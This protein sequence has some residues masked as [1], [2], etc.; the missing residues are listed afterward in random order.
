MYLRQDAIS[1]SRK[2]FRQMKIDELVEHEK[3]ILNMLD[4][5]A[6]NGK[7]TPNDIINNLS[8]DEVIY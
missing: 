6:G 7:L 2:D 4:K 8:P 3:G 1:I 5:G